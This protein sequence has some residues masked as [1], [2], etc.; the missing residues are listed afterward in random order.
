M[1][2]DLYNQCDCVAMSISL[3]LNHRWLRIAIICDLFDD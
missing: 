2:Y 3:M 1:K